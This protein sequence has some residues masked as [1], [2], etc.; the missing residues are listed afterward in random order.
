MDK[1]VDEAAALVTLILAIAVLG[2]V[3]GIAF[4]IYLAITGVIAIVSFN[5]Y[6][7]IAEREAQE[8]DDELTGGLSTDNILRSVFGPDIE[9]P[10]DGPENT[11]DWFEYT[12]L[13]EEK[14][15]AD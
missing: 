6:Y 13:G 1:S 15:H 5:I 3:L 11:I 4:L 9:L 8:L 10:T 12:V 14:G 7:K 2:V